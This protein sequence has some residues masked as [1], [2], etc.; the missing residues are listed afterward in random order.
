MKK[1]G[2]NETDP[3]YLK[4]RQVLSAIQ[5]QTAFRNAQR[6]KMEA[7]RQ[8]QMQQAQAGNGQVIN[9]VNGTITLPPE[10]N[11]PHFDLDD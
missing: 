3:E 1:Q 9:G 11:A 8:R 7:M 10:N 5:Q 6:Q 4:V 2:V